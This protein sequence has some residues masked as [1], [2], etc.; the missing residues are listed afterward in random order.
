MLS[1]WESRR[2]RG[3]K[4][5]PANLVLTL[6]PTWLRPACSTQRELCSCLCAGQEA[7]DDMFEAHCCMVVK[8]H[9]WR[10]NAHADC[11]RCSCCPSGPVRRRWTFAQRMAACTETGSHL[12]VCTRRSK[13]LS[14]AQ[15]FANRHSASD[16]STQCMVWRHG[17]TTL[18]CP[19]ASALALVPQYKQTQEHPLHPLQQDRCAVQADPG[20]PSASPAICRQ[21]VERA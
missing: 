1:P 13:L 8:W 18:C 4:G 17:K 10:H 11:G 5:K 16:A 15:R 14:K 12:W 6:G 2:C 20:T 21:A 3:G 9:T 7:R 19:S